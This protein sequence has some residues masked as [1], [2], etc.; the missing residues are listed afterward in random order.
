M[1]QVICIEG[2]GVSSSDKRPL[3]SA[4]KYSLVNLRA[5][6]HCF[7]PFRFKSKCKKILDIYHQT[8]GPILIVAKSLGAYRLYQYKGE[9][10]EM[11]DDR[12]RKIAV[13]TVDPHAPWW[14]CGDGWERPLT[15]APLGVG[16][17]YHYNL[18]QTD[19]YPR[20]AAVNALPA[21][22]NEQ[23]RGVDHSTIVRSRA[24]Q[25]AYLTAVKWLFR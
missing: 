4:V 5:D 23:V 13:V 14:R 8:R 7:T 15:G 18:F 6:F 24:A 1:L 20:G 12:N 11:L 19:H 17:L 9:L 22:R 21:G 25:A 10:A 2:S 16:N 3:T